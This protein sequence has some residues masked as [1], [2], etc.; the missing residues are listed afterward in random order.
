MDKQRN[1]QLEA[2]LKHAF[3]TTIMLNG[4]GTADKSSAIHNLI[5]LREQRRNGKRGRMNAREE[6]AAYPS[7]YR[8]RSWY[9]RGLAGNGW[10][11]RLSEN[12]A[13]VGLVRVRDAHDFASLPEDLKNSILAWLA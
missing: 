7:A 5:V 10:K 12:F 8:D 9:D 13:R 3:V 6:Q 11:S 4:G 1:E 2:I